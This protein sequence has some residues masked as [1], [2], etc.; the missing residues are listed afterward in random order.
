MAVDVTT[1][2]N[3]AHLQKKKAKRPVS[4]KKSGAKEAWDG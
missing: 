4:Y 3:V 2:R 1:A